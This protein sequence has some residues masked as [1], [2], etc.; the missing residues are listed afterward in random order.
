[1]ASSVFQNFVI[2][3]QNFQKEE[4]CFK[5]HFLE[6]NKM[7]YVKLPVIFNHKFQTEMSLFD[8]PS[9]TNN[10]GTS[11]TYIALFAFICVY[12]SQIHH[13]NPETKLNQK[14]VFYLKF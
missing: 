10:C 14:N 1:M 9:M 12:Q 4:D 6:L 2:L 5:I 13:W 11:K 3:G 8:P 7:E